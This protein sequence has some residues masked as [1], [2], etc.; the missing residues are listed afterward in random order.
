MEKVDQKIFEPGYKACGL[1][2]L[3]RWNRL[4]KDFDYWKLMHPKSRQIFWGWN[5]P[6]LV[7]RTEYLF[8][9]TDYSNAFLPW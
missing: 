9:N 6:T 3:L 4:I 2:L 5:E 1:A 7:R 8:S